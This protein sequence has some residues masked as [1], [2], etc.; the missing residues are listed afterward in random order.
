MKLW[1]SCRKRLKRW[2]VEPDEKQ[3]P[4]EWKSLDVA[5]LDDLADGVIYRGEGVQGEKVTVHCTHE[6]LG[7]KVLVSFHLSLV[8]DDVPISH[9]SGG[10]GNLKGDLTTAH[11]NCFVTEPA[12]R[13]KGY[14]T[15]LLAVYLR[16]VMLL[17]S[18]EVISSKSRYDDRLVKLYQRFNF[19]V[20]NR[21]LYR[22]I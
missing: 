19:D 22:K 9:I 4:L 11:L 15:I 21:S 3:E 2:K 8:G 20:V 12:Y 13:S 6:K 17:G 10:F 5:V 18:T 14:G 16:Y 7:N 1:K